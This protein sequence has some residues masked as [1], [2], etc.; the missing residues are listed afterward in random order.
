MSP[1]RSAFLPATGFE[2]KNNLFDPIKRITSKKE[3]ENNITEC[4]DRKVDIRNVIISCSAS[5]L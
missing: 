2:Q 5:L 1:K 3:E 4:F